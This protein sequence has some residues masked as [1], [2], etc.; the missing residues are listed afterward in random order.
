VARIRQ[1]PSGRWLVAWLEDG[2]GSRELSKTFDTREHAEAHKREVEAVKERDRRMARLQAE[3][4]DPLGWTEQDY[5]NRAAIDYLDE[6]GE[7]PEWF[8]EGGE[9]L[10]V[11]LK[12]IIDLDTDLRDS[13]RRTYHQYLRLYI[14]PTELGEMPIGSVTPAVISRWWSELPPGRGIRRSA[15]SMLSKALNRAVLVGDL[16]SNPL[17][18]APEVK[19]PRAGRAEEYEPLTIAQIEAL[20]E[21]AA[22]PREDRGNVT[23]TMREMNGLT[24]LVLAYAGLRAGELGGL[25]ATDVVRDGS[26][27]SLRIRRQAQWDEAGGRITDLKTAAA[28]RQV[29]IP[30]SLADEIQAFIEAHGTAPDGRIFR[31]P[32]DQIRYASRTNHVVVR[33][34]KELGLDVNAHQLRHTAVSLLIDRGA[35][36]KAIQAFVG[37]SDIRMTLGTY[38]HLFDT[39][40]QALADIMEDLRRGHQDGSK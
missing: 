2:R 9:P 3:G 27:C 17:R 29:S 36:P 32:K 25:H 37:H 15:R 35:N 6:Q 24:V 38:G 5:R 11:Y 33:A 21:A 40:G 23:E 28:R 14:A 30:C 39:G 1:K 12:K 16:K 18:M 7:L 10:A 13:T 19:R 22:R 31:G 20:A 34:G 26:K 4:K 8:T